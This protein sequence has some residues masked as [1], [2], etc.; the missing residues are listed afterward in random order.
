MNPL[1]CFSSIAALAALLPAQL[2]IADGNMQ[3]V[4]G[5]LSPTS[6]AP[7]SFQLR[8]DALAINHAFE[9]GWYYR[10]AGDSR[11]SSFRNIGGLVEAPAGGEHGDRDFA[12]VDARGLLKASLDYDIYD[13]GPASGVVVTRLTLMNR[14]A[15][16]LTVDVFCYHDLDIA[17]SFGNDVCTGT[18]SSHYVTDPSGVQVE[19]RALGNDL[20]AVGAYPTIRD[21]LTNTT[22]DN[23]PGTLPPFTGDYT[24][25]FQWQNRTLQPFEQK[26]FNVYLVVD[27]AGASLPINEHYGAGSSIGFEIHT[28]TVAVQ[29]NSTTRGLLVQM[30]GAPPSTLQRFVASDAPWVPAPFIPGLDFWVDPFAVLGTFGDMTSPS[31]EAVQLFLIPPIPYLAGINVYFQAFTLDFAAPNGFAQWSAGLRIR[32]GKI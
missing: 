22:V 1:P 13:C 10:I 9:S 4:F 25:A 16:P 6:H 7:R 24:G 31:G 12:D 8:S 20:S 27:T 14:S 28:Q 11:E 3:A 21:L 5:A 15:A 30:K 26:S 17:G 19:V 29:D 18:N 2:T 32:L 23:L